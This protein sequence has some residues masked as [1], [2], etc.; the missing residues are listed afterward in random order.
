MTILRKSVTLNPG[1]SKEVAFQFTPSRAKAYSVSVNGL[2]GSFNAIGGAKGFIT[3]FA[4]GLR[5]WLIGGQDYAEWTVA[6]YY[7]D[8]DTWRSHIYPG[9]NYYRRPWESITPPPDYPIDLNNLV[10]RVRD[11]SESEYCPGTG[12]LGDCLRG[13][14]G[15][16]VVEDGGEYI[17][18]LDT[19]QLIPKV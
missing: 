14:F 2:A 8:E 4:T 18:D 9:G 16:F 11:Y 13:E 15:P 6:W 3:L 12:Y 19:G 1:E 5:Q 17:I 10:F 7:P